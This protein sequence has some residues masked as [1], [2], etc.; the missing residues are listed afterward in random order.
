MI[1]INSLCVL[2]VLVWWRGVFGDVKG[3]RKLLSDV[4][5]KI[6]GGRICRLGSG[7]LEYLEI[8][9]IR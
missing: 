6:G 3:R 8:C 2:L 1:F 5:K 9:S 7:V 4:F